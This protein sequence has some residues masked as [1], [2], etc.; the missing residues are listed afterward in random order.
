MLQLESPV[1]PCLYTNSSQLEVIP[2]AGDT[3]QCPE[4][5]SRDD[6]RNANDIW[7]VEAKGTAKDP[8]TCQAAPHQETSRPKCQQYWGWEI[9]I[10]RFT[11]LV[12][13]EHFL[14]DSLFSAS[15]TTGG[16]FSFLF[17]H[18]ERYV[19]SSCQSP[20][21]SH[22]LERQKRV[23]QALQLRL[24]QGAAV[25]SPALTQPHSLHHDN[26]Q[27]VSAFPWAGQNAT[28]ETVH[29]TT[30]HLGST[31]WGL[32]TMPL[33]AMLTV[34]ITIIVTGSHRRFLCARNGDKVFICIITY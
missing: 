25:P 6:W 2:L 18:L 23:M 13:T 16:R 19:F 27:P 24:P 31:P 15:R 1:V 3:R 5:F 12:Q 21:A 33:T 30:R 4:T 17:Y 10:R 20:T 8:T 14:G 28:R 22:R 29:G 7:G 9:A 34:R 26:L 11:V 32:A